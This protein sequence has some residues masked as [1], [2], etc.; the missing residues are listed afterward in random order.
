MSI[1]TPPDALNTLVQAEWQS[2]NGRISVTGNTNA[3]LFVDM[4]GATGNTVRTGISC[5]GVFD[6][7]G[8][9]LNNNECEVIPG[10]SGGSR[11]YLNCLANSVN[12]DNC[13]SGG[14]M[15]GSGV[16]WMAAFSVFGMVLYQLL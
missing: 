6:S 5:S 12:W 2:S 11:V 10:Y 9:N 1:W 8:N 15:A 4:R 13:N 14:V 3:N 7:E 16:W